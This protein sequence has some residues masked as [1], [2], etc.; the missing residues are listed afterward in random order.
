MQYYKDEKKFDP[1]DTKYNLILI[2]KH[3]HKLS[4]PSRNK[5]PS[6]SL[7]KFLRW[8]R[9]LVRLIL[10]FENSFIINIIVTGSSN[11]FL[12]NNLNENHPQGIF[13]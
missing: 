11:S 7:D 2:K 6:P 8:N 4:I 3:A 13:K 10:E 12:N 5:R 9:K 1:L